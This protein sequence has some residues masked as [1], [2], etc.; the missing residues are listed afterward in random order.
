MNLDVPHPCRLHRY[1]HYPG[2][3]FALLMGTHERAGAMSPVRLLCGFTGVLETI[4]QFTLEAGLDRNPN[5]LKLVFFSTDTEHVEQAKAILQH[6]GD[7]QADSVL[8]LAREVLKLPPP[9]ANDANPIEI[10]DELNDFVKV[11]APGLP[12]LGTRHYFMSLDGIAS[13]ACC[14]RDDGAQTL[15]STRPFNRRA[16][17]PRDQA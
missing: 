17:S 14:P 3:T 5:A 10:W 9:G 1:D 15:A 13:G 16:S 8:R 2:A 6:V 12:R 7:T 4:H 11:K